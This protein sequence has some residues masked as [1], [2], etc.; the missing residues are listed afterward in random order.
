[1][2]RSDRLVKRS[3]PATT[4]PP[5]L[6]RRQSSVDK[7]HPPAPYDKCCPPCGVEAPHPEERTTVAAPQIQRQLGIDMGGHLSIGY[8]KQVVGPPGNGPKIEARVVRN[9]APNLALSALWIFAR[10]LVHDFVALTGRR[11]Q[12]LSKP[13]PR[14]HISKQNAEGQEDAQGQTRCEIG[15]V[16]AD[17]GAI[18]PHRYGAPRRSSPKHSLAEIPEEASAQQVFLPAS[19]AKPKVRPPATDLHW[20]LGKGPAIRSMDPLRDLP[21]LSPRPEWFRNRVCG[22]GLGRNLVQSV[23]RAEAALAMALQ[24]TSLHLRTLPHELASFV[25]HGGAEIQAPKRLG[26]NQVSTKPVA[27]TCQHNAGIMRDSQSKAAHD[28]RIFRPTT[29]VSKAARMSRSRVMSGRSPNRRPQISRGANSRDR[30]CGAS[31][32]AR[33]LLEPTAWHSRKVCVCVCD[34]SK[35]ILPTRHKRILPM[36]SEDCV[37]PDLGAAVAPRP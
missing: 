34:A 17:W 16:G 10:S 6:R 26:D 33:G 14:A 7:V 25:C 29:S 12:A 3:W 4:S 31:G 15:S 21:E 30:L 1:M 18:W 2:G 27:T 13:E 5:R 37:P 22:R 28:I 24:C 35:H 20:S 32:C 9:I 8:L 11:H 36:H 19:C 23:W